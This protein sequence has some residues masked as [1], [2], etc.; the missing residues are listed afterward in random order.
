MNYF[1]DLLK[2]WD[3]ENAILSVFG[4]YSK[5]ASVKDTLTEEMKNTIKKIFYG[6]S[7]PVDQIKEVASRTK[8]VAWCGS[9]FIAFM[10][11]L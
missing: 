8:E 5:K 1:Q 4:L 6:K 7:S 2:I 3:V 11:H 10:L 9:Y